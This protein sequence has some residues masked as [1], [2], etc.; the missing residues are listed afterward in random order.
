MKRDNDNCYKAYISNKNLEDMIKNIKY[1]TIRVCT[2]EE[3]LPMDLQY[4]DM[5]FVTSKNA[6]YTFLGDQWI[7]M[8]P[9]TQYEKIRESELKRDSILDRATILQDKPSQNKSYN[10]RILDRVFNL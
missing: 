1:P 9:A 6:F 7:K 8:P 10:N 5:A 3:D 4:G 2:M